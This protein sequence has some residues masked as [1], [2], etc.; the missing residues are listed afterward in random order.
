M[1]SATVKMGYTTILLERASAKKEDGNYYGGDD[2][3]MCESADKRISPGFDERFSAMPHY[4][5]VIY[6]IF[7]YSNSLYSYS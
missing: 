5:N 6:C 2:R 3:A 1:L 4:E 7:K